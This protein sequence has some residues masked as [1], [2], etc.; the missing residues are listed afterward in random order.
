[1]SIHLKGL[2]FKREEEKKT[3]KGRDFLVLTVYENRIDKLMNLEQY[4]EI[5][6]FVLR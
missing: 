2:K 5:T 3:P 1:M 4:I 6:L